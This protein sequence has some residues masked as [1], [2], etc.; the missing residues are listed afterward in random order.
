MDVVAAFVAN[1]EA[2]ELMEPGNRSFHDPASFTQ[3]TAM[4]GV[5]SGQTGSNAAAAKLVAVRLRIVSAIA[6]DALGAVTGPTGLAA[7]GRNGLHQGQK[8][9]HVVSIRGGKRR[10]QGNA[11]RICNDMVFAP[12]FTAIGRVGTGFCPP[13][14]ARTLELS[15]TARDQSIRSAVWSSVNNSSCNRS[16]TPAAC[17]SRKRRQQVIPH[18]QPS[19]CGNIAQGMPLRSTNK[20]PV[21]ACRLP[22]AGRPPLVD[23]VTGGSKGSTRSHNPS[24]TNGLAMTALL[25]PSSPK[26]TTSR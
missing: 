9:S 26:Q 22:T 25:D 21:N 13:S 12:R 18:P 8:L 14:K 2:A 5:S 23:S 1:A 15:T 4:F 11:R 10:G 19:S 24:D 6:L 20:M 7:E 16:Q 3:A 17:Q